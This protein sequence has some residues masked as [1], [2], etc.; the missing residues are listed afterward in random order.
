MCGNGDY[1]YERNKRDD[2]HAQECVEKSHG[3]IQLQFTLD[4]KSFVVWTMKE[5]SMCYIV[6]GI[7]TKGGGKL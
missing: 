4:R 6:E 5:L 3:Y 2:K 1:S 7:E